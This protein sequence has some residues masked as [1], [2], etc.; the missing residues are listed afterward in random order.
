MATHRH[1][2]IVHEV[3][4]RGAAR[5][6][7]LANL[8]QVSDMTIRRDLEVLDT[9]GLVVK[10]HGGATAALDLT[11]DEPS[12]EA[13]AMRHTEEKVAIAQ[14]A[15]AMATNGGTIGMTAGTTTWR[16]ATALASVPNLTV[17]TNSVRVAEAFKAHPRSDRQ[18]ILSGGVRT[19]SDAL[20]GP[21]SVAALGTLHVDTLFIGVHGMSER[22][23]YST[24][25]LLEADTNRAFLAA[26]GRSVVLADHT[27]WGIAG[28][29][30][31]G[32]LSEADVVITDRRITSAGAEALDAAVDELII[33]DS[34]SWN[35]ANDN[36]G[37][38]DDQ[39]EMCGD[40]RSA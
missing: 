11:S 23:G 19:R 25:N 37:S 32:T 36:A 14:R 8:L 38:A 2:R 34:P 29:S 12:F 13:K 40:D 15:A 4:I 21:I 35:V 31:F 28:L 26:A 20:V 24:P 1:E 16:L 22:A 18:L 39:A 9:A 17:V 5:V 30:S 27:K 6:G 7:D 3:R 33:V 10:V